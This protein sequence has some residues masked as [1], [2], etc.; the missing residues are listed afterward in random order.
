METGTHVVKYGGSQPL[1]TGSGPWTE[2]EVAQ[3]LLLSARKGFSAETCMRAVMKEQQDAVK[4][5]T[6]GA[7]MTGK[8][9]KAQATKVATYR[10]REAARETGLPF[11]VAYKTL[12]EANPELKDAVARVRS[13]GKQTSAEWAG[14]K[15]RQ[16]VKALVAKGYS[17]RRP[18]GR[19]GATSPR[20]FV[21]CGRAVRPARRRPPGK[22]FS[23]ACFAHDHDHRGASAPGGG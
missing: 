13:T 20:P 15:F 11:S 9:S 17:P 6:K 18:S 12:L 1:L 22:R 23:P 7:R 5:P 14:R 8:L 4:T 16:E 10:A 2:D 19:P 21:A 3:A